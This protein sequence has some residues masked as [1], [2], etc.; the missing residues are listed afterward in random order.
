MIKLLHPEL[1]QGTRVESVREAAAANPILNLAAFIYTQAFSSF[2]MSVKIIGSK[3][4]MK[5]IHRAIFKWT[6]KCKD[7]GKK[8]NTA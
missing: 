6:Q 3:A 7:T 1:S 4:E 8:Q 5:K 2:Y